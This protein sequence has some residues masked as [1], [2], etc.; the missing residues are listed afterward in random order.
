[1]PAKKPSQGQ[2]T[3][4]PSRDAFTAGAQGHVSSDNVSGRRAGLNDDK[5]KPMRE[6]TFRVRTLYGRNVCCNDCY[7]YTPSTKVVI[8]GVILESA[9]SSVCQFVS[10]HRLLR[11]YASKI[12]NIQHLNFHSM[13]LMF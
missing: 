7:C 10:R 8:K 1:M 12:L 6:G 5:K 11:S 4:R 3:I 2:E 13:V 9:C